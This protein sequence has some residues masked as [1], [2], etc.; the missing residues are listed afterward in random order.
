MYQGVDSIG[1]KPITFTYQAPQLPVSNELGPWAHA[2]QLHQFVKSNAGK[3]L[4]RIEDETLCSWLVAP[5][6]SVSL[7]AA[8]E[9][10]LQQQSDQDNAH[11]AMVIPLDQRIYYAEV[12]HTLVVKE[13]LI[14]REQYQQTLADWQEQKLTVR[15]YQGGQL[16]HVVAED[17]A[18][19]PLPLDP[20]AFNYTPTLQAFAQQKLIHP[21]AVSWLVA[22]VLVS[23]IGHQAYQYNERQRAQEQ[24]AEIAAS[25]QMLAPTAEFS[26]GKQ[27]LDLAAYLT[28]D[29]LAG[30]HRD[31]L[32]R[33]SWRATD[34]AL[35]YSGRSEQRYP[36]NPAAYAAHIGGE[37][38]LSPNEWRIE[39]P[40]PAVT[41]NRPVDE[42]QSAN[43]AATVYSLGQLHH[44]EVRLSSTLDH[45]SVSES[46]FSFAINT[47]NRFSLQQ[48]SQQM[49]GPAVGAARGAVRVQRM[50]H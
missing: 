46:V 7:A 14:S 18:P 25:A 33:L 15:L 44:A 34:S 47:P 24:A 35:Y 4:L 45:G 9:H 42:F 19:T 48:L 40:L 12:D 11:F 28:D 31:N 23:A 17:L 39:K 50:A 3:A 21:G 16:S 20:W 1:G 26:A 2:R 30:L 38:L 41:D 8:I 27:I 13:R 49:S 43:V 10:W 22:L 29:A 37:F 6:K 32:E 5:S 36:T